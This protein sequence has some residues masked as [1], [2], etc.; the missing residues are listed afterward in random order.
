MR[1][2]HPDA[3]GILRRDGEVWP[4]FLDWERRAVRPVTMAARLAPYPESTEEER[5]SSCGWVLRCSW[6]NGF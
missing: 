3:F 5:A 1:S 6:D 2:V 4:F